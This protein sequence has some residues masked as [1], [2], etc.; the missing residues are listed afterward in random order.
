MERKKKKNRKKEGKRK[1]QTHTRHRNF[2]K[3]KKKKISSLGMKD[4]LNCPLKEYEFYSRSYI[5]LNLSLIGK[6]TIG[7]PVNTAA[8]ERPNLLSFRLHFRELDLS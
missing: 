1:Q 5:L 7:S 2:C 8:A 3:K 4:K 6:P